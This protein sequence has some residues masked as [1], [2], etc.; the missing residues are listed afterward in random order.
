MRRRA[1][2]GKGAARLSVTRKSPKI[3]TS[4]RRELEKRLAES[5]KRE[6]ATGEILQE[7]DRALTEAL[8]QQTATS[9]ILRVISSSPTDLKPVLD[10]V[11]ES[12][13]RLCNAGD[14][15]IFRVEGDSLKQVAAHGPIPHVPAE[16]SL[17]LRRDVMTARAVIDRSVVHVADVLAESD[18]EYAGS[19][20]YA[21]RL[22]YRTALAVPML[23]EGEAIGTIL[24]RR[25][26][27]RPFTSKQIELLQT[28]AD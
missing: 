1:K 13:A 10:A 27:V 25:T 20:A 14:A 8:E 11:A 17:P 22:G 21:G 23:R 12:A 28:F 5:R 7:K 26:E 18:A 2:P 4:G 3:E 9:E 15:T 6:K 24:L 19:K 16:E